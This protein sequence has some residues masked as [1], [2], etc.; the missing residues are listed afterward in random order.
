MVGLPEEYER[1][2][3]LMTRLSWSIFGLLLK[4]LIRFPFLSHSGCVFLPALCSH[5]GLAADMI[6]QFRERSWQK[7]DIATKLCF[8][9]GWFSS[10]P[11]ERRPRVL[12]CC[13]SYEQAGG[14]LTLL[15]AAWGLECA[16]KPH[17]GSVLKLLAVSR[18]G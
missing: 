14:E 12:P 4:G 10:D 16:V 1:A 18:L 3:R 17:L 7:T 11:A 15:A 8:S 6:S 13:R 2:V 5:W 9:L